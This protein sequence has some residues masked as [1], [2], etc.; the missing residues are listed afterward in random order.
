MKTIPE[1]VPRTDRVRELVRLEPVVDRRVGCLRQWGMQRPGH[2]Q[3][4][5]VIRIDARTEQPQRA[6]RA[7]VHFHPH[8]LY[9]CASDV[10]PNIGRLSSALSTAALTRTPVPLPSR[11]A[12]ATSAVSTRRGCQ[13]VAHPAASR[14][15]VATAIQRATT[16]HEARR[17]RSLAGAARA[18]HR[19]SQPP[20]G[21]L[22][23]GNPPS[24]PSHGKKFDLHQ[25][26]GLASK[27]NTARTPSV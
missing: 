16:R 19:P 11:R 25:R 2:F 22:V 1:R 17:R 9:A 14:R 15:S 12:P 18:S 13:V 6:R 7:V 26:G 10:A 4:R 8:G 24:R 5:E 3:R 23:A 27:I 20:L 21:H